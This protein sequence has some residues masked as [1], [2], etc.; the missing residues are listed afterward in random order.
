MEKLRKIIN[1]HPFLQGFLS[2]FSVFPVEFDLPVVRE[3]DSDKL[4]G[5]WQLVGR[6]IERAML[7]FDKKKSSVG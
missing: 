3:T 5:D 2:P 4:S 6:D 1:A 7:T